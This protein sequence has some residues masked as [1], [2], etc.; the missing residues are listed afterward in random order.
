LR[1]HLR[2]RWSDLER[3]APRLAARAR[4]LL[5]DPG[6][7]LVA[8]IRRDGSPRLSPV[9]PL[10]LDGDLWL[11]MLWQSRKAADLLAD[12]RILVH[13]I[14]TTREGDPGEVKLR[15]RAVAVDDAAPRDRY[16]E[17]VAT[18]GWQPVEPF[19][20]LF[21]IEIDDV[22]SVRYEHP[23]DQYVARWPAGVE[24]VRRETSP[25]SVGEPEPVTDLLA[26]TYRADDT[27]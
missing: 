24:F 4:A 21:R 20:H 7:L 19:F 5:V 14:V 23:G 8:T 15:G 16:R 2:V 12:D 18:L 17:A 9:E 13:S 26:G 27:P 3:D 10:L 1:D 11:S 6:V 22:T 25:T